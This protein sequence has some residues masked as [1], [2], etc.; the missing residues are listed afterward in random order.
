[1][2]IHLT[3]WQR[4]F[5]GEVPGSFYFELV[6]R[7]AVIYFLLMISMRLMGKRMS[8]QLGRNELAALVSLA[9]AIGIPLQAPDRGVL[10]AFVIAIVVV[11]ME[12]WIASKTYQ[13]QTFERFTQ[14]NIDMLVKDLV[15]DMQTLKKIHLTPERLF[16]QLRAV[17][18]KQLGT[19]QRFYMEANG[20]FTVIE[21]KQARPGLSIIPHWDND[22][23]ARFK[24]AKEILVCQ[25]CGF[26]KS[27][28]LDPQLVCPKCDYKNWTPGVN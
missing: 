21:E 26:S 14:G 7:A 6:I 22:Y 11:F 28:H 12:R 3:D 16:A 25:R 9:A 10:P 5:V 15:I 13:S 18:I 27:T 17:G 2:D 24:V 1:N 20:S 8:L 4:I 19:G 23:Q